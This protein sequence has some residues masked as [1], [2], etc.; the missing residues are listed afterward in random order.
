M[1]RLA[2]GV[3]A[4]LLATAASAGPGGGGGANANLIQN[5]GFEGGQANP[6]FIFDIPAGTGFTPGWTVSVGTIDWY[7]PPPCGW[8]GAGNS[9]HSIDLVGQFGTGGVQQTFPTSG[10]GRCYR[11]AFF[12]AGNYDT[13]QPI[14]PLDV[15]INGVLQHHFTFDTTGHDR[16]NLGWTPHWVKFI[17]TSPMTTVN[18]VSNDLGGA[19]NAG[20]AIDNVTANRASPNHCPGFQ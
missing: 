6:C 14:K 20:A 7:G 9:S 8:V 13:P 17:A 4:I 2:F 16:F 10:V 1:R 12:L 5:G 15:Y 11:V 3:V 18:F 19:L